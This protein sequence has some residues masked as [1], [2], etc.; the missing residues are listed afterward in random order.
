VRGAR[1]KSGTRLLEAT[2]L[3]LL[4]APERMT[5]CNNLHSLRSNGASCHESVE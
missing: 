3:P 1:C 4:Y 5:Q 2:A